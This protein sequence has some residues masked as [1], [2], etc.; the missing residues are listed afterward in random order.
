MQYAYYAYMLSPDNVHGRAVPNYGAAQEVLCPYWNCGFIVFRFQSS[1]HCHNQRPNPSFNTILLYTSKF[2][3]WF[4]PLTFSNRHSVTF[5][6]V[7]AI[8]ATCLASSTLLDEISIAISSDH[9]KLWRSST[10]N[11]LTCPITFFLL[12]PNIILILCYETHLHSTLFPDYET[13]IIK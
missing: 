8:C 2:F 13:N 11:F 6:L 10:C 7:S 4:L 3:K 1:S 9:N 12:G 5:L